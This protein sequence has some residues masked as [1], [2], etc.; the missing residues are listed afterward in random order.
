MLSMATLILLPSRTK[1]DPHTNEAYCVMQSKDVY[2]EHLT[3]PPEHLAHPSNAPKDTVC[4]IV[5]KKEARHNTH[6]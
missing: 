2:S 3:H 4:L 6:C 5:Q 1:D